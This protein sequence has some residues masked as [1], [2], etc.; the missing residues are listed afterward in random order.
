[1]NT[2]QRPVFNA[3]LK[4]RYPVTAIASVLHR[5]SGVFLFLIIPFLLWGL[6]IS[7]T[8]QQGFQ[9]LQQWFH[10]PL[11]ITL[12]WLTIAALL[13]HLIAGIRHL[14]M[15]TGVGESLSVARTTA[16]TVFVVTVILLLLIGFWL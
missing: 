9:N 1:M 4:Y 13:Y 16:Y 2:Q 10:H 8:S 7:L 3:V 5:I 12:I 6:D 15:D 11:V 14:L